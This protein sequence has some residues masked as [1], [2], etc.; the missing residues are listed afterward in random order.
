[1]EVKELRSLLCSCMCFTVNLF[2]QANLYHLINLDTN[3]KQINKHTFSPQKYGPHPQTLLQNSM[4]TKWLP[5]EI[6]KKQ[7]K[8]HMILKDT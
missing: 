2:E 8:L 5:L 3:N 6:D 4:V 1:M 7:H